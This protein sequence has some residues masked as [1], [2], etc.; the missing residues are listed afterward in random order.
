MT[1]YFLF[2]L[3]DNTIKSNGVQNKIC[4]RLNVPIT[5]YVH[6]HVWVWE[7]M[8]VCVCACM[9]TCVCMPVYMCAFA[10]V[11]LCLCVCM[12]VHAC[13]HV[14]V[15]A[16]VCRGI[17]VCIH[18]HVCVCVHACMHVYMCV[19]VCVGGGVACTM[20]CSNTVCVHTHLTCTSLTMPFRSI[21]SFTASWT[22]TFS[23][24]DRSFSLGDLD[25]RSDFSKIKNENLQSH[26]KHH[27]EFQSCSQCVWL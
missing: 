4:V 10:C 7:G 26:P 18:V 27:Q 21:I 5:V 22:S 11:F 9:H 24:R 3:T 8:F 1:W 16:C 14:W 15:C 23:A 12:C 13:M 2:W 17:C 19:C 25:C 6:L 20:N